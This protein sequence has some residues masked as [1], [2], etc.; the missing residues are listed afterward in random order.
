MLT[1]CSKHFRRTK[2]PRLPCHPEGP[3]GQQTS[4]RCSP[5]GRTRATS[6]RATLDYADLDGSELHLTLFVSPG[7]A[8]AGAKAGPRYPN[9]YRPNS[10]RLAKI[11]ASPRVTY[12][13]PLNTRKEAKFGRRTY[14]FCSCCLCVSWGS[15]QLSSFSMN[16]SVRIRP[17]RG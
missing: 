13:C 2:V 8:V 6:L 1:K 5:S 11:F 15:I 16:L 17:I 9:C 3:I 14:V 10:S 7:R 4:S 12:F